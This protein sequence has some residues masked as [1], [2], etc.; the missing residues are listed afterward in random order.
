MIELIDVMAGAFGENPKTGFW[1]VVANTFELMDIAEDEI[2]RMKE[3]Y[4]DKIEMIHRS[5]TILRPTIYLQEVSKE[6]YRSHIK[7]LLMRVVNGQDTRVATDAELMSILSG[8][9]FGAPLNRTGTGLY[10]RLF[11]RIF[12]DFMFGESMSDETLNDKYYEDWDGQLDE[13]DS[14]ERKKLFSDWRI[15]EWKQS[16]LLT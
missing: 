6:V 3:L 8:A 10:V 11:R 14:R 2:A 12:P 16:G 5:F 4:P 9:T 13:V 1:G 15:I 7:E